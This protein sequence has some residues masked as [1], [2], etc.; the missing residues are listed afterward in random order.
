MLP[1][2]SF[3]TCEG[4]SNVWKMRP[5]TRERKKFGSSPEHEFTSATKIRRWGDIA[6]M[7][8]FQRNAAIHVALSANA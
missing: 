7:A 1:K 8:K 4:R 3:C 5:E 2:P 6:V